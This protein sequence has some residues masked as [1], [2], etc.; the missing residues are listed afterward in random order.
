MNSPWCFRPTLEA[1]HVVA[2]A[3]AY[4]RFRDPR[5]Q[6]SGK[7]LDA[8]YE[9]IWREA[10]DQLGAT[11][12]PLGCNIAD[13]T[14]GDARVRTIE[15][16]CSIDDPVTIALALNKLLSYRLLG[17]AGLPPPAHA[18]FT[19]GTIDRALRFLVTAGGP[20]VIKPASG[21]GGGRGIT[22]N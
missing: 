22:T 18:D 1:L 9:R 10:A 4:L 3:K 11:Y 20:C 8:F 12:L 15:N 17:D 21:T 14:L 5:R 19:R 2:M 7:H 16:T 13:I 6:R